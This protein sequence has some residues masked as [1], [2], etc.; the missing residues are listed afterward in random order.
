MQCEIPY[1]RPDT[2][3]CP[4]KC[5]AGLYNPGTF[6]LTNT[7]T[8]SISTRTPLLEQ[9][10]LCRSMPEIFSNLLFLPSTSCPLA[11]NAQLQP[12]LF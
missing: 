1:I 8:G 10:A 7:S 9:Q 3:H 2:Y 11:W 5:P 6:I 4:L 12:S